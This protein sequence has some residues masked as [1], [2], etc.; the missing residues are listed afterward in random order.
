MS[1]LT[2]GWVLIL[3]KPVKNEFFCKFDIIYLESFHFADANG[4]Q[5]DIA[6]WF[7]WRGVFRGVK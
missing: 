1:H 6:A 4:L 2:L 3:S 7:E 5:N